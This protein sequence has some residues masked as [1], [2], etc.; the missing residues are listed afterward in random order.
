[1]ITQST[2]EA[3]ANR[4]FAIEELV[5]TIH[6]MARKV[7]DLAVGPSEIGRLTYRVSHLLLGASGLAGTLAHDL[8]DMISECA[9]TTT[10]D[11]SGGEA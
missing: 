2:M 9:P 11:N 5:D 6:E 10:A 1:M 7:E 8:S 3:I 4:A